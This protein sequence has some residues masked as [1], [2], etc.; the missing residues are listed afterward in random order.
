MKNRILIVGAVLLVAVCSICCDCSRFETLAQ[1]EGLFEEAD[2]VFVGLPVE[3]LNPSEVDSDKRMVGSNVLLK[4]INVEKGAIH[5]DKVIILQNSSNCA[6]R[7]MRGDTIVVFGYNIRG[8]RE[9]KGT[10]TDEYSDN[11][12][13]CVGGKS[14]SYSLYKRLSNTYPAVFTNKCLSF[15]KSDSVVT[16]FIRAKK[17]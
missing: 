5:T 7:F 12:M 2:V 10:Y 15:S 9:V 6:Q 17:R 14:K 4:V 16:T 13:F 8:I 1:I 11:K 3:N